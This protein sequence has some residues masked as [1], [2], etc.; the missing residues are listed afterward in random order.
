VDGVCN[1]FCPLQYH[2]EIILSSR[3]TD[4]LVGEQIFNNIDNSSEIHESVDS[5]IYR[6]C[7][8]YF[9]EKFQVMSDIFL[10]ISQNYRRDEHSFKCTAIECGS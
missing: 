1:Y 7:G 5:A 10:I 9:P 4:V 6:K 2:S 3:N 8:K